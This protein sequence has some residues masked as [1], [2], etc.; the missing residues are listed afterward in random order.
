MTLTHDSTDNPHGCTDSQGAYSLT[1]RLAVTSTQ[2][3]QSPQYTI[4]SLLGSHDT[5]PLVCFLVSFL[6]VII[7]IGFWLYEVFS[8]KT[9]SLGIAK[10]VNFPNTQHCISS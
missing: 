6:L 4:V 8:I 5:G 10:I 9:R 2:P 7:A 1:A 3:L